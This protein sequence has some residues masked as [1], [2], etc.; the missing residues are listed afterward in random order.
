MGVKL[1]MNNR[2]LLLP[3]ILIFVVS[4]IS[5]AGQQTR[6]KSSVVDYLYPKSS[7]TIIQPSIPTLNLPLKVGIAFVPEQETLSRGR[8]VWTGVVGSGAA[9]TSA[10]KSNHI[11][12]SS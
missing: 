6:A 7:T 10:P 9:L 2:R 12:I 5:C 11:R 1:I 8:N 4:V 3:L